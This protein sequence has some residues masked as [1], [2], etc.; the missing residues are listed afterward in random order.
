MKILNCKSPHW[1]SH[2]DIFPLK[3]TV[4]SNVAVW[5]PNNPISM[6][7]LEYGEK[8]MANNRYKGWKFTDDQVWI[9]M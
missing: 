6:L 3:A 8:S 1:F 4:F 9:K 7:S 5:R 2:Q